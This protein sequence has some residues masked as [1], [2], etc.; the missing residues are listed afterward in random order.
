MRRRDL[1][2]KRSLSGTRMVSGAANRTS[3]VEGRLAGR[4]IGF[5]AIDILCAI[6]VELEFEHGGG[7]QNYT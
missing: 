1:A 3:A 6:D 5:Q 4:F 2:E 7:K